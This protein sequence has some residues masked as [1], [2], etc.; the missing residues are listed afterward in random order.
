MD[1]L[2]GQIVELP[3]EVLDESGAWLRAG[4]KVVLLPHRFVPHEAE[5]GENLEV[6]LFHTEEG[7]LQATRRLPHTPLGAVGF[8]TVRNVHNKAAYVDIGLPRDVVIP[9]REQVYELQPKDRSVVYIGYDSLSGTLFGST[10][11]LHHLK[12]KDL[13]Y[14]KGQEVEALIFDKVDF[15]WRAVV[16]GKHCAIMFEKEI[17]HE[18]KR[19]KRFKAWVRD[20]E[21][22][23]LIVSLQ[24]DGIEGLEDACRKIM[25]FLE[26]HKGYMRMNDNTD[27]EEIKLRLR[28][29]KK[30]FKRAVGHLMREGYV[31]ITKRGVKLAKAQPSDQ[32][33][34]A[35]S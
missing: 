3:I 2:P 33:P 14:E 27:P 7:E 5:E 25:T 23:N 31:V 17:F 28:M 9:E 18:V 1:A 6:S 16:N 13:P 24:R 34:E 35:E 26:S 10:R 19:G 30:T 8:L 11:L 22:G 32:S 12:T 15:G 21:D 4:H 29:S 20:I